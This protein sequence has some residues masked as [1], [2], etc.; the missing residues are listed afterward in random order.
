MAIFKYLTPHLAVAAQLTAED[1]QQAADSGFTVVINN[2]PDD[3]EAGQPANRDVGRA[4]E[5]LGLE[6]HYLPVLSGQLTDRNVADYAALAT[7][8]QDRKLLLFCRSGTRC[9]FLWALQQARDSQVELGEIVAA[10]AGAGYDLQGLLAR[11]EA[12]R[13]G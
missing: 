3:E 5:A 2:R 8:L 11:M 10:A 4:A 13:R 7:R 6:Y 9:T 12:L 1:M